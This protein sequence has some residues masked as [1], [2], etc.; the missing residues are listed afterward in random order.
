MHS[1]EVRNLSF[2]YDK[3]CVLNHVNLNIDSGDFV[4]LL[5]KSGC[6]KSTL[7]R[8]LAGLSKPLEGEITINGEPVTGASLDRSVV[9]QDYSLFPWFTTG[10]NITLSL[11]QKYKDMSRSELKTKAIQFLKAVGLDETVFY[12]YPHELSGGMRQRCATC[13]S[14]ALNPPVLLMDEPFGALDAVTRAKLQDMAHELWQNDASDRGC[15]KTVVFVTHDVDE[16]LRL[17]TKIFILGSS[18]SEIIYSCEI[19]QKGLGRQ[20][21]FE[22][23]DMVALRNKLIYE[24]NRDIEVRL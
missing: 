7:L 23:E 6:G 13:R 9:F 3:E 17:A 16:A 11:A 12:K 10:K 22:N 5:G 4:C 8:L 2:A 20:K 1:I 14:F 18:P 15:R 24:I 19:E 21:I